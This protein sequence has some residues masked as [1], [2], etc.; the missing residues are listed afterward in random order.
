MNIF[1]FN[2]S[3][4][5]NKYIYRILLATGIIAIVVLLIQRKNA[6]SMN[7]KRQPGNEKKW[8]NNL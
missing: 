4:D 5:V 6:A 1:E 7:N 2:R 8:Y 3:S